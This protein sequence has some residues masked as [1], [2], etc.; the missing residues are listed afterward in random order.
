MTVANGHVIKE[1]GYRRT[2]GPPALGVEAVTSR[3]VRARLVC[4]VDDVRPRRI[5]F[6]QLVL[7]TEGKDEHEVDFVSHPCAPGTLL[8][9]RPGQVQRTVLSP[10]LEAWFIW[11]T[12]DF[13]PPLP[14]ADGL[15]RDPFSP[16]RYELDEAAMRRLLPIVERLGEES[17]GPETDPEL[18]RHLLATLILYVRRLPAASDTRSSE[19]GGEIFRSFLCELERSFA[20]TRRVEDY[21]DRL[22]YT[23]KT[24]TRASLAATGRSAKHVIDARVVLEAKRLLA[25]TDQTVVA[26]ASGLGFAEP[27]NFSK[28]FIRNVGVTPLRF[29]ETALA[30]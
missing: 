28:F 13:P 1:V 25:H 14:A 5:D 3:D 24:L 30:P 29:R 11:F 21:A 2:T 4:D 27:T 6:H 22:G 16:V 9:I 8:W 10:A 17:A 19:E 15:L 12:P 18:L 23:P 26:I 20:T 7:V